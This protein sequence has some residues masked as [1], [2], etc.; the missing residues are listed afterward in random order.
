MWW[1]GL[2]WSCCGELYSGGRHAKG[3]GGHY[4]GVC[5]HVNSGGWSARRAK[6]DKWSFRRGF[7]NKRMEVEGDG[8]ATV[9]GEREI[10]VLIR[11]KNWR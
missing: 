10:R 8:D 6:E 3:R 9:L 2:G 5:A 11:V 1:H 7:K 4:G